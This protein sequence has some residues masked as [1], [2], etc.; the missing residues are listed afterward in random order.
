VL[1]PHINA[2]GRVLLSGEAVQISA[3]QATGLA[4]VLHELA[5]NAV[6]Y[7]AFSNASG[8]VGIAW[9]SSSDSILL[10]WVEDGG[11]AIS[12]APSRKGFGTILADRTA[13][14]TLMGQIDYDWQPQG[15][16]VRLSMPLMS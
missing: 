16:V 14:S 11:P 13:T 12:E 9:V 8:T 15:L 3:P 7:G 4:L 10:E 5:T 1:A 6:K 2:D